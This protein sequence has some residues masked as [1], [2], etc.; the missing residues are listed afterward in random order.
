MKTFWYATLASITT[1]VLGTLISQSF[2][3]DRGSSFRGRPGGQSSQRAPSGIGQFRG[4]VPQSSIA[5]RVNGGVSVSGRSPAA[6]PTVRPRVPSFPVANPVKPGRVP[7]FPVKPP[8]ATSPIRPVRP[9]VVGPTKPFPPIVKPPVVR[10]NPPVSKPPVVGPIRPLPPIVK[11][12]VVGPIKPP[13]VGPI[14]PPVVGPIKPPVVGPIKPPVI[15]PIKPPV[16]GP[17]GPGNPLPPICPP[18]PPKPCPP[19]CPPWNPGGY[20]GPWH[21]LPGWFGCYNPCPPICVTLPAYTSTPVVVTETVVVEG[22]APAATEAEFV[23]A[24]AEEELLQVPVGATLTLSDKSLGE[25][26]G[27]VVLQVDAMSVPGQVTE[28]KADQVTVTLPMFGLSEPTKSKIWL[29]RADGEVANVLAVELTPADP[30]N[31]ASAAEASPLA[32][33]ALLQE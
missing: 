27:Q 13:V 5:G 12:P 26:Q 17:I 9:P 6:L 2:G 22:T 19:I 7:T 24:S 1:L 8:A 30:Q 18:A 29:L 4:G 11:P 15:G 14:K 16:V 23:P 20:C 32:T 31:D 28:W 3:A 10:P 25:K 21:P 33:A